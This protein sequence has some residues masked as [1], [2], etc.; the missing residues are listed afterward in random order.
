MSGVWL[1]YST[2]VIPGHLDKYRADEILKYNL[3]SE[4]R[5]LL[6]SFHGRT[7]SN[8]E[9]YENITVRS[10][11]ERFFKGAANTSI[12]DFT[13]GYFEIVGKSHFCLVPEGTS[14]WTN[15]LYTAFFAGCIPIILS[16]NFVLPFQDHLDWTRFTVRWPQKEVS[17][18]LY[19]FLKKFVAQKFDVVKK[20]KQLLDDNR[21][22]FEWYEFTNFKRC[23]PY[24]AMV[25][26]LKR[27]RDQ[28]GAYKSEFGW[29]DVRAPA[30]I[31]DS[32]MKELFPTEAD[33]LGLINEHL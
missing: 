1:C 2:V 12:G 6:F 27:R 26:D 22:W 14:S 7:A 23:S 13:P 19:E 33:L 8:H 24:L 28:M 21:C 9:Y 16:D 5:T 10:Q 32:L 17:V 31:P 20:T 29:L 11:I 3:P 15:H 18:A 25:R 30:V 4:E